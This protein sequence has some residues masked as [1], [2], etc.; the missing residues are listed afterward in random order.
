MGRPQGW[1]SREAIGAARGL[2]EHSLKSGLRNTEVH[3]GDG[4]G[5]LRG[6]ERSM[7]GSDVVF[8]S[9]SHCSSGTPS[10]AGKWAPEPK[11]AAS[12]VTDPGLSELYKD[13]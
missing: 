4:W 2:Q 1:P 9:V 7:K 5:L 10:R 6:L 8:S 3:K 11:A 12:R 13:H